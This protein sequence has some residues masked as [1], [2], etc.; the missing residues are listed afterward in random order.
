MANHCTCNGDAATCGFCHDFESWDAA[1]TD[2]E[3]GE[4]ALDFI[5][6]LTSATGAITGNVG[7]PS[8]GHWAS[9][10]FDGLT[11]FQEFLG[12]KFKQSLRE[13]A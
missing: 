1:L 11:K 3:R 8:L 4:L 2:A 13:A 9:V 7:S 5:D 12:W 6:S 10:E